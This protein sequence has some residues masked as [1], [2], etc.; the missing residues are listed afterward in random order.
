MK[1][2][3]KKKANKKSEIVSTSYINTVLDN[4]N[5]VQVTFLN[6]KLFIEL[7]P[8]ILLQKGI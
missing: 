8:F 5:I 6:I 2:E 1:R 4:T 3:R 7:M